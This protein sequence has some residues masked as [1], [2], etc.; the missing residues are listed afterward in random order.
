MF[1]DFKC[2][3]NAALLETYE[4]MYVSKKHIFYLLLHVLDS[5]GLKKF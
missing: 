2:C 1:Y 3:S 4:I 5:T